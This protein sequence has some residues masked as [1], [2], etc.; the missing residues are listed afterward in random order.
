MALFIKSS[1]YF[2]EELGAR[3]QVTVRSNA[4][5]MRARL[6]G[7]EYRVT[8]PAGT[9]VERYREF[10]AIIK[11]KLAEAARKAALRRF[12]P[13]CVLEGLMMRVEINADNVL[14]G[15][16]IKIVREKGS[17]GGL[18]LRL[19]VSPEADPTSYQRIVNR[20]VL[21][22]ACDVSRM[23]FL[24]EIMACAASVGLAERVKSVD[25]NTRRSDLG[26]CYRDGR[27]EFSSRLLF[28]PPEL[29]RFVVMHELAHLTHGNHSKE[30]HALVDSYLGGRERELDKALK[31]FRLPLF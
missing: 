19:G 14:G 23:F 12:E 5:N 9:T 17:D 16:G 1:T 26:R 28:Y 13:G 22:N 3:V 10:V 15:R 7:T 31:A 30:F 18:L 20:I 25:F 11:E 29:R 6:V 27:I 8:V 4:R 2:E 24:K 21:E